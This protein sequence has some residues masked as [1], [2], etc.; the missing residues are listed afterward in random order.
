MKTLI[1]FILI[2]VCLTAYGQ[3]LTLTMGNTGYV[4]FVLKTPS[5]DTVDVVLGGSNRIN[6]Y[7]VYAKSTVTDSVLM[8]IK[9]SDTLYAQQ[10][11]QDLASG[12]NVTFISATTTGKMFK[13]L[14]PQPK[15]A[16]FT[17]A[18]TDSVNVV[19][20]IERRFRP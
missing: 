20:I 9:Q 6:D 15:K 3:D 13:M 12:S 2:F 1:S 7:V 19:I 14:D 8:F 18:A 4:N 5:T 10:G 17:F 11:L 16:R